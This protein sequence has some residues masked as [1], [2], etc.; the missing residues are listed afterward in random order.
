VHHHLLYQARRQEIKWGGVFFVKSGKCFF[1]VENGGVFFLKSGP[2][3]NAGCIMY[4]ISIFYFK[5]YLFGGCVRTP[6]P[7]DL[8]TVPWV[9]T[10]LLTKING[11]S[12]DP[13]I[14]AGFMVTVVTNRKITP[15][16][17]QQ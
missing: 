17:L 4:S 12:I 14:F 10:S 3:L 11:I 8:Y 13:A 1:K 15:L 9:H 7:T 6:L 2:F 16:H 5:F